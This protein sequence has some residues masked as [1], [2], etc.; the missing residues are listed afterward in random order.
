MIKATIFDFGGV[1]LDFP[2]TG[3][4]NFVSSSL[5]ISMDLVK[6]LCSQWEES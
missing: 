5:N 3:I 1:V 4:E 6:K 2:P